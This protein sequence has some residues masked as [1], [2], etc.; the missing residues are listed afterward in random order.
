MRT[1]PFYPQHLLASLHIRDHHLIFANGGQEAAGL[2]DCDIA[3]T[4]AV[5]GLDDF[6]GGEGR[7]EDGSVGRHCVGGVE[8]RVGWAEGE[9][10]VVDWC[11]GRCFGLLALVGVAGEIF[12]LVLHKRRRL[13]ALNIDAVIGNQSRRARVRVAQG[14]CILACFDDGMVGGRGVRDQDTCTESTDS[15]LENIDETMEEV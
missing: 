3:G 2:V 6:F 13:C 9:F 11:R 15:M 4:T 7:F 10:S 1:N 12:G 14:P 8:E 5:V